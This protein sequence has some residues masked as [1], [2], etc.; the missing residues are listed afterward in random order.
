MESHNELISTINT[1]EEKYN[2]IQKNTIL[3]NNINELQKKIKILISQNNDSKI[4]FE[5]LNKTNNFLNKENIDLRL[6]LERNL[7][8]KKDMCGIISQIENMGDK[9]KDVEKKYKDKLRQKD[10]IISQLDEQLQQYELKIKQLQKELL[11]CKIEIEKNKVELMKD[12]SQN[13]INNNTNVNTNNN[14]TNVLNN[15]RKKF[16]SMIIN[17]GLSLSSSFR[18]KK[19]DENKKNDCDS[20]RISKN[21]IK[22]KV[23][24]IDKE[25]KVENKEILNEQNNSEENEN[26]DDENIDDLLKEVD[27]EIN[28]SI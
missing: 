13:N 21:D 18:N 1:I 19:Y 2:T 14:L 16:N 17:N 4:K 15:D 9:L 25:I 11:L 26:S 22:E 5:N 6:Q 12:K 28:K 8:E 7:K 24:I 3:L 20:L 27:E 10:D 23:D